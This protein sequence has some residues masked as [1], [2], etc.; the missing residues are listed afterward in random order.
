MYIL[1]VGKIWIL[2]NFYC[3]L[4]LF[5]LGSMA[6]AP[7][8]NMKYEIRLH[9]THKLDFA[10]HGHQD[11]SLW[12]LVHYEW[13]SYVFVQK[14]RSMKANECKGCLLITN[15]V[16]YS[17]PHY[18]YTHLVH[19]LFSSHFHQS[20]VNVYTNIHKNSLNIIECTKLIDKYSF[21]IGCLSFLNK[22]QCFL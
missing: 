2:N 22:G 17:S 12:T 15:H 1:C 11:W 19:P 18:L 10:H 8:V 3:Y 13:M 6:Q 14:I 4:V 9:I 16:D 5:T 21:S 20:I 7:L